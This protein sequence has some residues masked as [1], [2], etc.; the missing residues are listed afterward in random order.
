MTPH[1]TLACVPGK[2]TSVVFKS[3][4]ILHALLGQAN[5]PFLD[6]VDIELPH[7]V[8]HQLASRHPDLWTA[9]CANNATACLKQ[10]ELGAGLATAEQKEVYNILR[11]KV[12]AQLKRRDMPIHDREYKQAHS[13]LRLVLL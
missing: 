7:D 6:T 10:Y 9:F 12:E 11:A 5:Q 8:I 13:R 4:L 3:S 1:G 2:R